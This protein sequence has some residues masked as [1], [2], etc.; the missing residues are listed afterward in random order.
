M[1]SEAASAHYSSW[2]ATLA[3]TLDALRGW[4]HPAAAALAAE[5]TCPETFTLPWVQELRLAH[6]VHQ[7]LC[8]LPEDT[9]FFAATLAPPKPSVLRAGVVPPPPT[10]FPL[11]PLTLPSPTD[12]KHTPHHHLPARIA[13]AAAARSVFSAF[14]QTSVESERARFLS[15][16]GQGGAAFIVADQQPQ[17]YPI[18]PDVYRVAVAR[19]FGLPHPA[20]RTTTCQPCDITFSSPLEAADHLAR[21]P[22][23]PAFHSAHRAI[24]GV[25]NTIIDEA[26]FAAERR[27][28]VRGLRPADNSRPA[29]ILIAGFG[30]ALQHLAIDVVIPGVLGYTG[31]RP[32]GG[33]TPGSAARYAEARKFRRDAQSSQPIAAAHRFVPFAVEEFGRLGEHAKALLFELAKAAVSGRNTLLHLPD[34]APPVRRLLQAKL[35]AWRQ[36]LSIA[37]HCIQAVLVLERYPRGPLMDAQRSPPASHLLRRYWAAADELRAFSPDPME[38][39]GDDADNL[40]LQTAV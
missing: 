6:A 23:S 29:D 27:N 5:L 4:S 9:R 7:P 15:R 11:R 28:E 17:L 18:P 3:S 39:S 38:L 31:W 1:R 36:R 14:Q 35:R 21:C 12:I 16:C 22:K 33:S 34:D 13:E 8:D 30:G 19:M 2:A 25:L 20:V 26:G 37:V 10:V 32:T 24:T 40:A